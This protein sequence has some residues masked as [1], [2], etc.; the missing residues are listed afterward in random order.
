MIKKKTKG[1]TDVQMFT[2]LA[3]PPP[4]LLHISSFDTFAS[5]YQLSTI[6]THELFTAV[7]FCV[8]AHSLTDIDQS[9]VDQIN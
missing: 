6:L 5:V 1:T 4:N 3:K 9:V 8:G 2:K 7:T